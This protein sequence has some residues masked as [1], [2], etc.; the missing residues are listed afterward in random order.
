MTAEREDGLGDVCRRLRRR[1]L[2]P[3]ER[4]DPGPLSGAILS[5]ANAQTV[6]RGCLLGGA[7]GDALGR[8]GEGR[9]PEVIRERYGSLTD[10][11]PWRGWAG[12]RQCVFTRI[13]NRLRR[14]KLQRRR[15]SVCTT[16][17]NRGV[18]GRSLVATGS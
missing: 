17:G 1:G 15:E 5:A 3:R 8:P 9:P 12:V 18:P 4:A 7:I 11:H 14:R 6:Y 2:F 13:R 16:G 10:F